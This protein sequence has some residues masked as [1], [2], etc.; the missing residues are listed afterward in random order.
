MSIRKPYLCKCIY[1][2]AKV[3]GTTNLET[4]S[5]QPE[6]N[7]MLAGFSASRVTSS[8]AC[9][10]PWSFV[11]AVRFAAPKWAPK[12]MLHF[13]LLEHATCMNAPMFMFMSTSRIGCF[14]TRPSFASSGAC[15]DFTKGN[16]QPMQNSNP[17]P[18]LEEIR[19]FPKI[20]GTLFGGSFS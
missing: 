4:F 8:F 9:F 5:M 17:Q 12:T 1:P 7:S 16:H 3:S 6:E 14:A 19:E 20:G 10:L 13:P 15:H 18:E 11:S 2:K